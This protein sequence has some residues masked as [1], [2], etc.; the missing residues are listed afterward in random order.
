MNEGGVDAIAERIGVSARHLGRLFR[1]EL[2]CSPV[3]VAQTVRA[4]LARKLIDETGW[5]MT[6]AAARVTHTRS[7]A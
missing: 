4:H 3:A 6:V 7:A 5:T 1:D 2:G